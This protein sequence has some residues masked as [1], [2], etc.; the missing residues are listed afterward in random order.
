MSDNMEEKDIDKLLF[1]AEVLYQL[2]EDFSRDMGVETVKIEEEE[3]GIYALQMRLTDLGKIQH[4]MI[5]ELQFIFLTEQER[6]VSSRITGLIFDGFPE[7]NYMELLKACNILNPGISN[8]SIYIKDGS[9]YTASG[10]TVG[11]DHSLRSAFEIIVT[12]L[13]LV[14][15]TLECVVDGLAVVAR[16]MSTA[17]EAAEKY[18]FAD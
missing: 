11:F 3:E 12:D 7:E 15:G 8:G 1:D 14:F 10:S 16:G 6:F 13:A 9:L 18:F 4:S 2:I 5:I 17:E